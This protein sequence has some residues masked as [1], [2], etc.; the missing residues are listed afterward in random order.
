MAPQALD[1]IAIAP[2]TPVRSNTFFG[3]LKLTAKKASNMCRSIPQGDSGSRLGA[4][5]DGAETS[6]CGSNTGQVFR[7]RGYPPKEVVK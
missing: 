7:R 6:G 4:K 2:T 3:D 1:R 5:I